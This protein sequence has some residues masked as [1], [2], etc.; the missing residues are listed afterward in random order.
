LKRLLVFVPCLLLSASAAQQPPAAAHSAAPSQ[1]AARFAPVAAGERIQNLDLFKAQLKQYHECTCKCG[2]Y[3]RDL[4]V[5][6]DR[7]IAFLRRRAAHHGAGQKLAVVFDIDETTLS[8]YPEMLRNDFEFNMRVFDDWVNTAS[9]AAIP[10]TLNIY[11]ESRELGVAVFFLTGRPESERDAT[12]RNLQAQGFDSWQGLILRS[13]DDKSPLAEQYKSTER[14]KIV[15]QGYRII[16]NVGD[17]WSD[18]QGKPEAEYSVKYPN[19]YY[20]IK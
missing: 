4:N 14:A 15:A 8:N 18:L 12:T 3:G 20:F 19:P 13:P 7:A 6:A 11:K 5:Q 2:C 17:Q 16:L 10:G 1:P 9:A